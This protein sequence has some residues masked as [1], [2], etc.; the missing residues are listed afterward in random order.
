MF[1]QPVAQAITT[2][3]VT[4]PMQQTTGAQQMTV[5]ISEYKPQTPN[6]LELWKAWQQDKAYYNDVIAKMQ[7]TVNMLQKEVQ[8][9]KNS[10][11]KAGSSKQQEREY[12][13]DEEEVAKETEWIVNEARSK[14]KKRKATTSPETSPQQPIQKTIEPKKTEGKNLYLRRQ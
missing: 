1:S 10:P 4:T 14:R 12:Y 13:T 8:N 2:A 11:A 7:E 5:P 3:V 9:L 6:E